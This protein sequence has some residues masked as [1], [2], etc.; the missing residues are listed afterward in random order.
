[1]IL[2]HDNA[3]YQTYFAGLQASHIDLGLFLFGSYDLVAEKLK[4]QPLEGKKVLW[5]EFY[6]PFE[7]NDNR[8]NIY[9]TKRGTLYVIGKPLNVEYANIELEYNAC[10]EVIR[11][12]LS[13]IKKDIVSGTVYANIDRYKIG[14]IDNSELVIGSVAYAGA[15]LDFHYQHSYDLTYNPAKWT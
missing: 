12:I 2:L 15:R 11:D 6:E 10:E 8:D 4:S 14:R 5:L 13:K 3:S 1:M 7:I 9:S